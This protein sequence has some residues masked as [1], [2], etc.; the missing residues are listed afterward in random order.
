[1]SWNLCGVNIR[2]FSQESVGKRILK[3]S[4]HLPKLLLNIKGYTFSETLYHR[5]PVCLFAY[6]IATLHPSHTA[7][8]SGLINYSS[9][10]VE[11]LYPTCTCNSR[12]IQSWFDYLNVK[13]SA[14]IHTFKHSLRTYVFHIVQVHTLFTSDSV[15]LL[16][17][18]L[19][20]SVLCI[21]IIMFGMLWLH[22][23]ATHKWHLNKPP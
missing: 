15:W 13:L 11:D 2:Q 12:R 3:I 14:T 9:M 17:L 1:M 10:T 6:I 18:R 4:P 21:I 16:T 22:Y 19:K 5:R 23:H 20:M 7:L 8:C